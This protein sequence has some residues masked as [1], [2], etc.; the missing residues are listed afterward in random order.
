MCCSLRRGDYPSARQTPRWGYS[1]QRGVDPSP[2]ATSYLPGAGEGA[3]SCG[4]VRLL[5]D[6]DGGRPL[7]LA[8]V[9]AGG[10]I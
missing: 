4:T 8:T 5:A 2:L 9:L 7:A 6:K 10:F 1:V 3:V